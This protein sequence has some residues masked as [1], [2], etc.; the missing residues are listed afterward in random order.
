MR[1]DGLE[2]MQF[3]GRHTGQGGNPDRRTSQATIKPRQA[4]R[5]AR[6]EHPG[7]LAPW[8]PGTLAPWHPGTLALWHLG[9][10]APWHPGTLA[11]VSSIELDA[12]VPRAVHLFGGGER[13]GDE[14]GG[15]AKPLRVGH[16]PDALGQLGIGLLP[17]QYAAAA[18][19]LRIAE[20]WGR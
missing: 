7:T 2:A 5:S 12:V 9:T 13:G 14:R 4:S 8:H 15:E 10:L 11:P 3:R 17:Q 20:E 16:V 1:L 6:Q 19:G 18:T